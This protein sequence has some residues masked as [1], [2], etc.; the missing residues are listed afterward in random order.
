MK[1]AKQYKNSPYRQEVFKM[2]IFHHVLST[3]WNIWYVSKWINPCYKSWSDYNRNFKL[4][5]K[6]LKGFK[7]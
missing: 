3:Y 2:N 4:G 1:K 7:L 5:Q 6:R